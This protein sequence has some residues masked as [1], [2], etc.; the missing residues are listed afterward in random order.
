MTSSSISGSAQNLAAIFSGICNI[1]SKRRK[2]FFTSFNKSGLS[3]FICSKYFLASSSGI[4]E[5]ISETDCPPP[6]ENS[7]GPGRKAD[8]FFSSFAVYI[9]ASRGISAKFP[10]C[11]TILFCFS[12]STLDRNVILF[13]LS[14]CS[15]ASA[16]TRG[17]SGDNNEKSCSSSNFTR[18]S[19][20]FSLLG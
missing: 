2:Y 13:S 14:T 6:L 4:L 17:C 10:V 15:N 11:R 1:S 16:I 8:F 19:N 9:I 7:T 20:M 5:S 18:N 3:V 12:G